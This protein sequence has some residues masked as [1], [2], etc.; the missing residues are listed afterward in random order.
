MVEQQLSILPSRP[1]RSGIAIRS[2]ELVSRRGRLRR[3]PGWILLLFFCLWVADAGISVLIHYGEL[4][5]RLTARLVAAFGR[6]VEVGRYNFSLWTGPVLE[7]QRVVVGEDPRFG[8]EYFMRAQSLRIRLSWRSLLRGHLELGTLSL[9]QPSLNIVQNRAGD[10]NLA[11]WLPRPGPRAGGSST[12]ASVLTFRRIEVGGGRVNFKRGDE[13]LPFALVSVEG[14][15]EPDGAGRWR[16]DLGATPWRASILTQ[17]AGSIH[18]AG[19]VGGTSS[20]L[21]PAVLDL[22][23]SDASIS[24][25]LRLARGDDYGVRGNLTLAFSAR[26]MNGEWDVQGRAEVR[27]LHRWDLA[28]RPDNP[29]LNLIAAV[30]VNPAASSLLLTKATLEAPHSNAIA[31]GRFSWLDAATSKKAASERARLEVS[32]VTIDLGDALAWVRAFHAGVSDRI[33]VQ[34]IAGA[35]AVLS[36]WPLRI[37]SGAISTVGADLEGADLRVGAHLGHV[38]LR[39]DHEHISLSPATLL[40]GPPKGPSTGSFRMDASFK[41][42]PSRIPS[43]RLA[44]NI[45]QVRDLIAATGSFGWDLSRGWDLAGPIRWDLR[46]QGIPWHA[47]PIGTIE[48]GDFDSLDG[49]SLRAPFL[50]QSVEQVRARADLRPG[51]RHILLLSAQAFGTHW[52]GTFDRRAS[53]DRWQFALS[54]D[55]LGSADLDRWLNPRWRESLIDRMLPFLNSRTPVSTMPKTLR[56]EGRLALGQF[57]LAPLTL[58]NVQGNVALSGYHIELANATAQFYGGDINGSLVADL[59]ALPSYRVSAAFSNVDLAAMTLASP[60]LAGLFAGSASGEISADARGAA[61]GD[62][63]ASLECRGSAKVSDAELHGINLANSMRDAIRRLGSSLFRQVSAT[64]TCGDGK[65]QF[66][67]L[68]LA[69]TADEIDASGNVD[70]GRN[71]DLHLQVLFGVDSPVTP[72]TAKVSD[73]PRE[74][75][76]LSGTLDSP[77]LARGGSY[78]RRAR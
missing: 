13:K 15:V 25:A 7:A 39:Y 54:A 59:R 41:P 27:R 31:S 67:D 47:E 48:I 42:G 71:L 29:A 44:G 43:V 3:W 58:R 75:Y 65:I 18:V 9:R 10:W 70:F 74:V 35:S 24:D 76:Q 38:D 46:W 53:D 28:L 34:G 40:F 5:K 36:G 68:A 12:A 8:Q 20:R 22:S 49:G 30:K 6:P 11:E 52:T 60:R 2:L 73:A 55:Q 32:N 26:T 33:A 61:R 23:W 72:T 17:Q 56:A 64:F 50:N 62:L 45:A 69:G 37:D 1:L 14:T 21:L 19:H 77:Q 4:Q 78:A 57:A 16:M 63:T 51:S 66:Q